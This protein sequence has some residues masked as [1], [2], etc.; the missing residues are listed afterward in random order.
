MTCGQRVSTPYGM[1]LIVG[2]RGHESVI[3]ALDS[4]DVVECSVRD[5]R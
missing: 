3:V 4:G 2:F 1:G 5:V